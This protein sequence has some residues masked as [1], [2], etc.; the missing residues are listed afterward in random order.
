[1]TNG[2]FEL[3]TLYGSGGP[4]DAWS[5]D[6]STNFS[7]RQDAAVFYDGAYSCISYKTTTADRM[8][9]QEVTATVTPGQTYRLT[10]KALDNDTDGNMRAWIGWLNSSHTFISNSPFTAYTTDS[11]SWQSLST[12]GVAPAN[13]MY[14]RVR[15][16]FYSSTSNLL[17][18]NVDQ[19]SMVMLCGTATPTATQTP[20]VLPT[21]TPTR[22]PTRTPT[23]TV[24][25]S[26]TPTRTPT[27][28]VPPTRTPTPTTS[29]TIVPTAT[30]TGLIVV[31]F[32]DDVHFDYEGVMANDFHVEGIVHSAGGS[33]PIV[34]DIL[35]FGDP[36]TGNWTVSGYHLVQI[37]PEEWRFTADFVTDGFISFCQWIHFGIFFYVDGRNIIADF[38]GW[39]T[40][41]GQPVGS[42]GVPVTGFWADDLGQIR[43]GAQTLRIMN[44]SGLSLTLPGIEMA[45][46]SIEVP[47]E[48]LFITGL[49]RLG[50]PS[51]LY[52]ELEWVAAPGF[53]RVMETNSFFDVA[54]E[55]IGIFIPP[56]G[57]LLIRGQQLM[58]GA[59]SG[60]WGWFWEQHGS[61][62]IGTPIPTITPLPTAT[63]IPTPTEVPC[64]RDGDPNGDGIVTQGDAQLAF[65]YYIDCLTL[66]PTRAQYCSADY[67][68]EG[69]ITPC[70]GSVTPGDAL[71]ILKRYLQYPDPCAKS[72]A[73]ARS[74]NS[75][76]VW[77]EMVAD[78][79]LVEGQLSISQIDREIEAF[80]V[81]VHYDPAALT[82]RGVR[83]GDLDPGWTFFDAKV[84]TSGDLIVS[85]VSTQPLLPGSGGTLAVIEF[86]ANPHFRGGTSAIKLGLPVDDLSTCRL[87]PSH[88]AQEVP[89]L[90]EF[91]K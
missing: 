38:H 27:N 23:I 24:P 9:E 64:I 45:V 21:L 33:P 80:G 19:V 87:V 85:G 17:N 28:T 90:Q 41:D 89:T 30:P 32:N 6:N 54:L 52:P 14:A 68:G 34:G 20:T 56:G 2:S 66:E 1:V 12:E 73:P 75:P 77:V 69:D 65:Y 15:I 57:F 48:D 83:P 49:G 76:A 84:Q 10:L 55:Q 79:D 59:A 8:L 50:Q 11:P 91:H 82:F 70:D 62:P 29:P 44:D 36:G 81:H 67:C 72:A 53:P 71:G 61:M 7:V 16:R 4:P 26:F 74:A 13:A 35:V 63:S 40:L 39:W 86:V 42:G 88:W 46:Y 18:I 60:D 43:P 51:P 58:A 31:G 37:N 3:W 47:L 22:T 5:Y 78:G 25:P